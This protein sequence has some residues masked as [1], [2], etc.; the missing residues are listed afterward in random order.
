MFSNWYNNVSSIVYKIRHLLLENHHSHRDET[1]Q[2]FYDRSISTISAYYLRNIVIPLLIVFVTFAVFYSNTVEYSQFMLEKETTSNTYH[3]ILD[4]NNFDISLLFFVNTI[5]HVLYFIIICWILV[6][7]KPVDQQ[8]KQQIIL[9]LLLFLGYVFYLVKSIYYHKTNCYNGL[10]MWG[11]NCCID[12][13]IYNSARILCYGAFILFYLCWIVRDLFE[14]RIEVER[15]Q[16]IFGWIFIDSVSLAILIS[17]IIGKINGSDSFI[18]EHAKEVAVWLSTFAWFLH[19]FYQIHTNSVSYDGTYRDYLENIIPNTDIAFRINTPLSLS[20]FS[21]SNQL[22]ILDIGCGDGQRTTEICKHTF[23]VSYDEIKDKIKLIGYDVNRKWK[24]YFNTQVKDGTFIYS[25][26]H[27]SKI[28]LSK[29]DLVIMSHTLY[30]NKALLTIQGIINNFKQGT[31]FIIR[32]NSPASVP[33]FASYNYSLRFFTE[34]HSYLWFKQWL[35]HDLKNMGLVQYMPTQQPIGGVHMPNHIYKQHYKINP[36][37]VTAL[38]ELL[39]SSFKNKDFNYDLMEYFN[40][41]YKYEG[42]RQIK[43]N[44]YIYVYVKQNQNEKKFNW[45][46]QLFHL[47]K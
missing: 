41:L 46:F 33:Y 47:L 9:P 36:K 1:T 35:S 32:G 31:V 5:I 3:N 12:T 22:T 25:S 39:R 30:T 2:D 7:R 13:L 10:S 24:P 29:I 34:R 43:C 42:V 18:V 27:L 19:Y 11:L 23:G 6:M 15:S 17:G 20:N 26:E 4:G 40:D 14:F 16:E 37:G 8:Y 45:R 28:D 44:D 38:S 21:H